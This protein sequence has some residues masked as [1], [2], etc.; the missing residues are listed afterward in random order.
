MLYSVD[1][2][3]KEGDFLNSVSFE[4]VPDS[5]GSAAST[6][7][8]T[9]AF[10]VT[11]TKTVTAA[12]STETE[13]QT[14]TITG[15]ATEINTLVQ[16]LGGSAVTQVQTLISTPGASTFATV[17]IPSDVSNAA[18]AASSSAIAVAEASNSGAL[19]HDAVLGLGIGLGLGIPLLVAATV[20]ATLYFCASGGS[21]KASSQGTQFGTMSQRA[22]Y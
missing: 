14:Q 19:P 17:A 7:V 3:G 18:A 4:V 11:M 8:E 6:V 10:T 2:S 13:T 20:A 5:S 12:A 15:V 9:D 1:S 16:T 22:Q 21:A